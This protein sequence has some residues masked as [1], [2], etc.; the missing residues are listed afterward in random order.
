MS[1][2]NCHIS[3][4]LSASVRRHDKQQ[5]ELW[6]PD[7]RQSC[8]H[9]STSRG[10][11]LYGNNG[12]GNTSLIPH[13]DLAGP[14]KFEVLTTPTS[15]TPATMLRPDQSRHR[16]LNKR[17]MK[18]RPGPPQ[19]RPPK[20]IG[21]ELLPSFYLPFVDLLSLYFSSTPGLIPQE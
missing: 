14:L 18:T 9:T 21:L 12:T 2:L 1:Y 17:G 6:H 19:S 5:S 20:S 10:S 16:A 3:N 4:I 8:V 7:N 11:V 13:S 15:L